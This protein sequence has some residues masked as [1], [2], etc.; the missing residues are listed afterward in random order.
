MTKVL[1]WLIII[2]AVI[3]LVSFVV[4]REVSWWVASLWAVTAIMARIELL[5]KEGK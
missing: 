2:C 5:I 1:G 4:T 3:S